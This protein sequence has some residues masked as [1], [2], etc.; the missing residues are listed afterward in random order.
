[1]RTAL[2]EAHTKLGGCAGYFRRGPFTFDAGAT[3]L[4]GLRPDEPVADFCDVLGL[5][6]Q[7]VPLSSYRVLLPDRTLDMVPD[8]DQFESLVAASFARGRR[9]ERAPRLFWRLQA[10]VGDTLF[11]A[12]RIPRMPVRGWKDLAHDFRILGIPGVLAAATSVLTV[13]DVLRLLGLYSDSAFRS[14]IA[15]LLQDTAQAG[16]ETVPFANAAACLQAY[17]LGMSRPR[18]GMKALTEGIGQ[19]FARLGGDL[20]TSTLVDQVEIDDS[21]RA[22]ESRRPAFEVVTRRGERLRAA[23][24]RSIY[25]STYRPGCWA[26]LSKADLAAESDVRTPPG[27]LSPGILS[28]T[29]RPSPRIPRSF[30]MSYEPTTGRS[31]MVT[32]C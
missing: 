17:R 24:S 3:A 26:E 14:L 11:R 7:A 31:T 16:P 20:R 18:G 15:M 22:G 2:L 25:H 8:R 12:R 23:R 6:F 13:R 1:M 10:V 30:S 32:T 5:D 21:L 29:A 9:S 27:A 28:S 4:M 19:E